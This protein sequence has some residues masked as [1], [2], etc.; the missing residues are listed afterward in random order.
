MREEKELVV[1]G[2]VKNTG[3]QKHLYKEAVD[4]FEKAA[5]LKNADIV[6]FFS[7]E[8]LDSS[9]KRHKKKREK[10]EEINKSHPEKRFIIV[11]NIKSVGT[12]LDLRFLSTPMEVEYNDVVSGM[13]LYF[14]QYLQL[15]KQ[16]NT[17]K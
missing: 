13:F 4:F 3:T 14:R 9:E 11:D 1:R 6:V 10:I 17:F 7:L 12:S 16:H 5:K 15:H 2:E 8:A